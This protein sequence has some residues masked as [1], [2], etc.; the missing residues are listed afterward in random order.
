MIAACKGAARGRL[1]GRRRISLAT[2]APTSR[3]FT[4]NDHCREEGVHRARS[5]SIELARDAEFDAMA[6]LDDVGF[7]VGPED[8]MGSRGPS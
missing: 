1:S 5:G 2:A 3:S 4:A 8:N 7:F 6:L